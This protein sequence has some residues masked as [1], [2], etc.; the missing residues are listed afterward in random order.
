M[1]QRAGGVR[2][3]HS[4]FQERGGGSTPTSALQLVL[5]P[6]DFALAKRLN[7]LWHSR[8]PRI[9]TGF[10]KNQPF[11]CYAAAFDG[12]YYAAAIWSN[13]VARNLPQR[14][15]LELRR[16]AV[17]PD[18]P[19]NTAS[20]VLGVMARL[21]RK[22]RPDVVRLVSYQ[23]TEVHTGGI[24]RAAGWLPV[25]TTGS[26]RRWGCPSR[27]R[28]PSQSEAVKQRWEKVLHERA[29]DEARTGA[30]DPARAGADVPPRELPGR[31][32][33]APGRHAPAG[34]SLWDTPPDDGGRD[35]VDR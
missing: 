3:A 21:I 20:R 5:E 26:Q 8:L 4:L 7:R 31:A 12:V 33:D 2:V 10:V 23:D 34:P 24:Y 18:A 1:R 9:G 30:A 32:A 27:P 29:D 16:L 6:I 28:P 25:A 15:W 13:P 17:A 22:A 14:S 19:R 35:E 11:L